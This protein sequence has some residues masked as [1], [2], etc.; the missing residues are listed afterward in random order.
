MPGWPHRHERVRRRPLHDGIDRST[1]SAGAAHRCLK[2]G[3]GDHRVG[4]E[5][6]LAFADSFFDMLEMLWGVAGLNVTTTGLV[7][8]NFDNVGP[9]IGVTAQ[10]I[11]CH[12][13]A[14]RRLGMIRSGIVLFEN[15]MMND[16]RWHSEWHGLSPN[17]I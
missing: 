1:G 4:I 2:R 8:F 7:G 6:A 14:I 17:R 11:D 9:K 16:C 13:I 5:I 12:S 15:W 10:R 3:A